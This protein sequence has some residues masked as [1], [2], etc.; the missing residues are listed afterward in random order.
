M[1]KEKITTLYKIFAILLGTFLVFIVSN[2]YFQQD[3][4]HSFGLM[5]G[6]GTKYLTFDK[7]LWE[8]LLFDRIGARMLMY[9]LFT[10][11]GLQGTVFGLIS[12]L[13]HVFNAWLVYIL[14]QR[15]SKHTMGSYVA[16]LFFLICISGQQAYSW[17]GTFAGT[18]PSVTCMLLSLNL[19]IQFLSTTKHTYLHASLIFALCSFFFKETFW[20][21]FLLYPLL[22]LF[23][24]KEKA[25]FWLGVKHF[26]PTILTGLIITFFFAR[27]VLTISGER[28]NYITPDKGGSNHLIERTLLYPF[29]GIA[30]I[31]IPY[32]LI[33]ETAR[34]VTTIAF[35]TYTP[36]TSEFDVF[37][38]NTVTPWLIRIASLFLIILFVIFYRKIRTSVNIRKTFL[39]GLFFLPL[40]FLPYI[41]LAK[42][43]AYLDSRYYYGPAVGAAILIGS[44]ASYAFKRKKILFGILGIFL[45]THTIYTATE[46]SSLVLISQER[47]NFISQ[48]ISLIPKLGDKTVFFITGDTPG[49]YGID[50][51]KVPFQSGL[52]HMLM[53]LYV[54]KGQLQKEFLQEKTVAQA[55]DIGFLYDTVAQGYKQVGNHGFG[56]YWDEEKLR[57]DMET[58]TFTDEN[59]IRLFYD[60]EVHT[61]RRL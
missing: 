53:V 40:S 56:Y 6:Y 23:L 11:F 32:P 42:F 18:V 61:V 50:E 29:E 55:M 5:L 38:Q 22:W 9:G 49:Y 15:I 43:D 25:S 2:L 52:G 12:G 44:V 48:T 7:T 41:V 30:Q 59:V 31:L 54:N 36:D 39:T 46:L 57:L 3:E 37:Y 10:L 51:L 1:A 33:F 28:A 8:S 14:C 58:S 16:G 27:S 26:L 19:Y 24:G 21:F 45:L 17:F 60:S 13:L 34:M 47:K 35:P 4:W 20:F